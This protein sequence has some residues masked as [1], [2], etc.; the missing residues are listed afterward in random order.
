MKEA[1][2]WLGF[3][4]DEEQL[5]EALNNCS[6]ENLAQLERTQKKALA[7]DQKRGSWHIKDKPENKFFVP[8]TGELI[9]PEMIQ[10]CESYKKILEY[11]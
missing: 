8:E 1:L 11:T 10:L 7:R 3:N 9:A 2:V 5:A 6:R 4:V